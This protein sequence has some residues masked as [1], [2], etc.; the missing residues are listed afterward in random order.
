MFLKP[1]NSAGNTRGLVFRRYT[2]LLNVEADATVFVTSY[3]GTTKYW[4]LDAQLGEFTETE[5]HEKYSNSVEVV[6]GTAY[7]YNDVVYTFTN[8]VWHSNTLTNATPNISPTELKRMLSSKYQKF[9][10]RYLGSFKFLTKGT[11]VCTV[12]QPLSGLEMD[13]QSRTI[14]VDTDI[15]IREQ[16][17]VVI[18]GGGACGCGYRCYLVENAEITQ[19]RMPKAFNIM[20]VTLNK[21]K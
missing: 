11:I 6:N 15:D 18:D 16:D 12:N 14:R 10:Y 21:I 3:L 2:N 19:K 17:I 5:N 4:L 8:G 9:D 13:L 1:S 20:R 7:V